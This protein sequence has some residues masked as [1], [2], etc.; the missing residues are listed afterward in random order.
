VNA[1]REAPTAAATA[2]RAWTFLVSRPHFALGLGM[3]GSLTVEAARGSSTTG[4]APTFAIIQAAVA[5]AALFVAWRAQER[6]EL[7][8]LLVLAV[9]FQVGWIAVHLALGVRADDD[10]AIVY[11]RDGRSLLHGD[12]PHSVYPSGAVLLFALE[13]WLGGGS[14]RVSNAFLMILAQLTIVTA[15]WRLNTRWS[16]WF[17]ALVALWPLNAF[18]WEFRYDLAPTSALVLGL[19][20]AQ[21]GRWAAAGAFFGLGAALKWTAGIALIGIACWLVCRRARNSA[22]AHIAAGATVFAAL[23]LP[24]LLWRPA[25]FFAAY[26]WQAKRGLIAESLFYLPLR[27][28]GLARVQTAPYLPAVRPGWAD[29]AAVAVQGLVIV[30]LLFLLAYVRHRSDAVALA[31]LLAAAFLL[32]NRVFSAQFLVTLLATW[33][34]AGSLVVR[35]RRQQLII[36]AVAA[37]ATVGNVLVYPA[38]A[39]HWTAWSAALFLCACSVTVALVVLATGS[40]RGLKRWPSRSRQ[41]AATRLTLMEETRAR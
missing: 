32:T 40:R 29:S 37:G 31:A 26:S 3:A 20:F 12:Y 21:R 7:R 36:G 23:N 33:A 2:E 39:A 25:A 38:Q 41:Y 8:R 6:L 5:G 10:S 4:F 1:F 28:I 11:P 35:T 34:V 13:T 17:A 9:L 27:S 18:Y 15:I 22:I 19:L 14:T 24:F 16:A 30:G